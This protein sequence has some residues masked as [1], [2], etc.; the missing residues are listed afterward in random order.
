MTMRD[1]SN[2]AFNLPSP[3]FPVWE[4]D[5]WVLYLNTDQSLLGRCFLMLKRP[6]TDVTALSEAEVAELWAAT[7][8]V[9]QALDR[10]WE[11]D[12]FNFAFLM[13][14]T[15]QVHW[16]IIPRYRLKREYSG[17][18]FVDP[19]FGGH[20]GTGVARTLDEDTYGK[21]VAEIQRRLR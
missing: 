15:R 19:E 12:H 18:T 4:T 2:T 9:R 3:G 1:T 5:A 6:E 7:R 14:Q 13:N 21:I 20:Y 11:P 10:A 17:G 16:H 8:Q